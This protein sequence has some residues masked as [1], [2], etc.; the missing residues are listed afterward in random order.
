LIV[1][2]PAFTRGPDAQ[3]WQLGEPGSLLAGCERHSTV[4]PSFNLNT[5]CGCVWA[6]DL[7]PSSTTNSPP[8]LSSTRRFTCHLRFAH[9]LDCPPVPPKV[10]VLLAAASRVCTH[11]RPGE[12]GS[13]N[14]GSSRGSTK[15][16]PVAG[17]RRKSGRPT[18]PPALLPNGINDPPQRFF[19]LVLI[20][21]R[22][23]YG[24]EQV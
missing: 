2:A 9:A 16:G 6:S 5:S 7:L 12:S 19:G 24:R 15:G 18:P 1:Y 21:S 8:A 4:A 14:R 3:T 23:W 20:V 22:R 17:P 11:E 10:S 13:A